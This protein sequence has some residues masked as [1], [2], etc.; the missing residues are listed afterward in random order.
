MTYLM[1]TDF[2]SDDYAIACCVSARMVIEAT[3]FFVHALTWRCCSTQLTAGGPEAEDSGRA[4]NSTAD[5]RAG[6]RE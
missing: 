5:G 1:R 3:Q 4:E 2:N 6:L